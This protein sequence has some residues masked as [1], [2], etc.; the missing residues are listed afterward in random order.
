MAMLEAP[1]SPK[2]TFQL[3]TVLYLLSFAVLTGWLLLILAGLL[4]ASVMQFA[5]EIA[6]PTLIGSVL[7][8]ELFK[9]LAR[10]AERRLSESPKG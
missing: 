7:C 4:N 10:R 1:M 2:H 5:N 9:R 8:V 3:F 6:V